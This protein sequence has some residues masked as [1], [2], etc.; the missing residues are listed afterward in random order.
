MRRCNVKLVAVVVAA[1]ATLACDR[2]ADAQAERDTAT[3]GRTTARLPGATGTGEQT[4]EEGKV[5]RGF[6][7]DI[8]AITERNEDF[9][10][11]VYTAKNLQL[12]LM[13]IPPGDRIGLE[14]HEDTDQFI[15]V[16]TGTGE[17]VID[18]V[19]SPIGPGSAIVIPA[20]AKHD[21]VNRGDE[22]LKLYTLYAPPHHRDGV[23]HRTR[24]D[25]E[26]DTEEFDG[27]TTE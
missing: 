27:K 19:P 12:V 21:V 6:V 9:R 24:A 8:H 10:R 18:D 16:E 11:V 17:V 23:V 3:E 26:R 20:G 2:G 15:R 4:G 13:A 1:L 5:M 25:A 14:T 22:P 7:D